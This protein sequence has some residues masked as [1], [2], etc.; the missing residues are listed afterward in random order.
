MRLKILSWNCQSAQNK[1]VEL[2]NFLNKTMH[3]IVLL[4]ETWLNPKVQIKIPNYV[5]LRQDRNS[6]SRYPHGG[7]AILVHSSL[8]NNYSRVKFVDLNSIE[9]IFI[10]LTLNTFSFTIGSIYASSSLN[11]TESK[12]DLEKLFSRPGPFVLAGDYNAKHTSW[13]NVKSDGKGNH[14]LRI[15]EK[16]Y[17]RSISVTI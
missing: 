14:L 4:Q 5:C 16:I 10:Q 17:V 11:T 1:V 15:C 8:Q 3:H 9:S 13:N 12:I 2:S 6:D 7:V